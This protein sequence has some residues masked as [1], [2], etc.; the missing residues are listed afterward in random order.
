MMWSV[1]SKLLS[2]LRQVSMLAEEMGFQLWFL[3]LWWWPRG[4]AGARMMFAQLRWG[5]MSCY[6]STLPR[7]VASA[8]EKV[9]SRYR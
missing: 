3:L 6:L 8:C 9:E 1:F 2:R 7:Q 5:W 4:R